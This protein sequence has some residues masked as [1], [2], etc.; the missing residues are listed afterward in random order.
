MP[1]KYCRKF[2]PPE[3]GAR[4]L[5]TTDDRQTTDGRAIAYSE[6][7]RYTNVLFTSYACVSGRK[8]AK[9]VHRQRQQVARLSVD[10]YSITQRTYFINMTIIYLPFSFVYQVT[11]YPS[12]GKLVHLLLK[13]HVAVRS[14]AIDA[15]KTKKAREH[16]LYQC[17]Y[18][19]FVRIAK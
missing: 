9:T 6:R 16:W 15:T 3:Q 5:Q 14:V 12:F 17:F 18:S 8:G 7:E 10:A 13:Q 11:Q 1:Q 2:E 4:T 19:W